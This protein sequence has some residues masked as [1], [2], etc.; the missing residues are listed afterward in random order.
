MSKAVETTFG[1]FVKSLRTVLG[2]M[3]RRLD[4]AG[5]SQAALHECVGQ[6][7]EAVAVSWLTAPPPATTISNNRSAS[8]HAPSHASHVSSG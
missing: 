4:V 1:K 7:S 5:E 6:L 8:A 3:G 2:D